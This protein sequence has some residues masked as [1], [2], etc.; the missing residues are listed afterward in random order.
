M[1]DEAYLVSVLNRLVQK[2]VKEK[3]RPSVFTVGEVIS[4]NPL[5]IKI[6][7]NIELPSDVLIVGD[8]FKKQTLKTTDG[9]HSVVWDNTLQVGDKVRLLSGTGG[10]QYFVIG[11]L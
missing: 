11:R 1:I 3:I 4:T 8:Q 5:K 6:S 10:Q 9:L 7:S 2:T